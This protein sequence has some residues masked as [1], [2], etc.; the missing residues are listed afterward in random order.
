MTSRCWKTAKNR[1]CRVFNFQQPHA[2]CTGGAAVALPKLPENVYSNAARYNASSAL[3]V[4]LL[5]ALNTNLPHQAYVRDQMIR[6]LEKMPEGQPVAVYTLGTKLTLLQDFTDDPAVLKKVA[7]EL[8]MK[9]SPLQDN[10]AGGTEHG[11]SAR[12]L[13]RRG[14]VPAQMMNA[15]Q[16][17]EQERVAFQTDLRVTYTLNALNSIARSLSGYPGRKNLIWISEAFP[18]SIDPNMELSGGCVCRHPQLRNADCGGRGFSDR[19][20]DRNVSHRRAR[21]RGFLSV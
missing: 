14:L 1:R 8:K 10:P 5:D 7:K 18:L 20:P 9:V 16:S 13:R 11:T 6:Y 21:A 12:R 4:V 17:F 19:R 2:E 3:N 15:M